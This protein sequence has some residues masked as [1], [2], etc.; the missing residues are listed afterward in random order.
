M[1]HG[2][3]LLY[4]DDNHLNVDGSRYVARQMLRDPVFAASVG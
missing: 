2:G 4:R 3:R 1:V